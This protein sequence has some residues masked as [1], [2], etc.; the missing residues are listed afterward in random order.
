VRIRKS[1]FTQQNNLEISTPS[2]ILAQSTCWALSSTDYTATSGTFIQ[3]GREAKRRSRP[4]YRE[5]LRD[6][7]MGKR[8]TANLDSLLVYTKWV[9]RHFEAMYREKNTNGRRRTRFITSRLL[10]G[11]IDKLANKIVDSGKSEFPS[12]ASNVVFFGNGSF[13][14][15]RGSAP[16]PRKKLVRALAMRTTVFV[17][18]EFR[19]SKIIVVKLSLLTT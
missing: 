11:T 8:K 18:D 2:H 5:A 15:M 6:E 17:L 1:I 9:G 3:R 12:T 13:K 7:D 4:G 19:T 10:Q 14:A 16:V